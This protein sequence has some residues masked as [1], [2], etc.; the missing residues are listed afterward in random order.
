MKINNKLK[1]RVKIVA[2]RERKF[3]SPNASLIRKLW[4]WQH[5]F[6]S[7]FSDML[8]LN[9]DNIHHYLDQ[10]T[11]AQ[12]HP[13]NGIYSRF[14][15]NKAFLPAILPAEY[16]TDIHV[17]YFKGELNYSGVAEKKNTINYLRE[18]VSHQPL[19]SKSLSGG[20]GHSLKIISAHNFED[21][22]KKV[23]TEK[24]SVLL[25]EKVIQHEYS[26]SVFPETVNTIRVI[27]MRDPI[28]GRVFLPV[29]FHRFG[30]R[31]SVPVDNVG[32]GGFLCPVDFETGQLSDGFIFRN[33]IFGWNSIHPDTGKRFSEISIPGWKE[34]AGEIIHHF[35]QSDWFQYGGLDVVVTKNGFKI[36]EI[37]SLPDCSTAQIL[38]PFF[39]SEKIKRFFISKG[40]FHD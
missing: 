9:K 35:N 22:I 1:S 23:Q 37:N 6:S 24:K 33:E 28:D 27:L 3:S 36:L 25:S 10:V 21:Y 34:I 40:I 32:K 19:A 16:T 13:F 17:V 12:Y 39:Q 31:F 26:S 14:L 5:G 18:F 2:D 11:Y 38:Q 29:A 30:T 7:G 4:S 15:D 8:K 20:G